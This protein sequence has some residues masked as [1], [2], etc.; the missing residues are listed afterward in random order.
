MQLIK[1]KKIMN[2]RKTNN[3]NNRMMLIKT[4]TSMKM[5]NM[6]NKSMMN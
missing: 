1:V 2:K 6:I 5:N 4:M 3:S